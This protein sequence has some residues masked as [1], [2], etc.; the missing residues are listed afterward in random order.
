M[1]RVAILQLATEFTWIV[2]TG[3]VPKLNSCKS[4]FGKIW[5][6]VD[7]QTDD[8]F[9]EI[10]YRNTGIQVN[11]GIHR[12]CRNSPELTGIHKFLFAEKVHHGLQS[13]LPLSSLMKRV[14]NLM[15]NP[16]LADILV[17]SK[18]IGQ[19]FELTLFKS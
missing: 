3:I 2:G 19:Y 11:T 1:F 15:H 7:V 18:V 8:V 9:T 10:E 12:N 13:S 14:L 6:S 17:S 4:N 16:K 5:L